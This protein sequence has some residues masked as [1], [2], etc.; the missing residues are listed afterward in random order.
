MKNENDVIEFISEKAVEIFD[1]G[2][3]HEKENICNYLLKCAESLNF[4]NDTPNT[5]L[6]KLVEII[7]EKSE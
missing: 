4:G 5:V 7:Q 6:K 3:Q 2:R 1:K